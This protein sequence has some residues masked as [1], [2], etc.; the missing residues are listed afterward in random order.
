MINLSQISL[1]SVDNGELWQIFP[2]NVNLWKIQNPFFKIEP[3]II[4]NRPLLDFSQNQGLKM[5]AID[6]HATMLDGLANKNSNGFFDDNDLPPPELWV[7]YSIQKDWL[8]AVVPPIFEP[9]VENIIENWT[10]SESIT[11]YVPNLT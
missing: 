5:I 7:D 6:I 3:I 9:M 1:Q 2:R 10:M 8:I 11:W 4:A